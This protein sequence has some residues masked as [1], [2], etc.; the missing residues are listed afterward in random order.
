MRRHLS[1]FY[2]LGILLAV[3]VLLF[4][5]GRAFFYF[6]FHDSFSAFENVI[7][8]KAFLSGF[9]YDLKV[10]LII[11][12]LFILIFFIPIKIYNSSYYL[13]LLKSLYF[14]LNSFA[15]FFNLLDVN[16]FALHGHRISIQNIWSETIRILQ[17]F[18]D[19]EFKRFVYNYLTI[20]IIFIIFIIILWNLLEFVQKRDFE[21][22]PVKQANFIISLFLLSIYGLVIYDSISY[23]GEWLG[24][25]YMKADRKIAPLIINNP[26]LFLASATRYQ[27]QEKDSWEN[28]QFQSSKQYDSLP[29]TSI[30]HICIAFIETNDSLAF[31]NIIEQ[32][33]LKTLAKLH[34]L[35]VL[36]TGL[37]T[38]TRYL[39]ETLLSFPSILPFD[40][41]QSVYSL[42]NYESLPQILEKEGFNTSLYSVGYQK[43]QMKLV[44]NFYGFQSNSILDS[45]AKNELKV[46]DLILKGFNT[47]KINKTFDVLLIKDQMNIASEAILI[48]YLKRIENDGLVFV[49]QIPKQNLGQSAQLKKSLTIYLPSGIDFY[50]PNNEIITQCLD[51]KPTILHY[52][53]QNNSF[54]AYGS[55]LFSKEEKTIFSSN[56]LNT[57]NL[58]RDSLLL[59]Y[60]NNVT[61][62][63]QVIRNHQ[64]LK[65][66]F[67]D[68][69]AIEKIEL[70][71]RINSIFRDFKYR[72]EKNK[73]K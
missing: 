20:L 12:S 32:N 10:V 2:D 54:I 26:Y 51:I 46:I 41:Y 57:Y 58:L 39:D 68:S 55:S 56:G 13:S 19:F 5:V 25:L 35:N 22:K 29:S 38:I 44:K 64:V 60:S 11:N 65:D 31:N 52:L 30:N 14:L 1:Q 17:D 72:T 66:D 24:K 53:N 36:S 45:I 23:K 63:I 6:N 8:L 34:R 50:K 28:D 61:Q 40:F 69:L 15:L 49:Y 33:G 37:N 43:K 59:T 73:M 71:D 3:P 70:E 47:D 16:S 7:L 42:N 27:P 9:E 48:A 67:K 4:T 18:T 62:S 21:K